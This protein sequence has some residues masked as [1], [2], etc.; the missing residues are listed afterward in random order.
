MHSSTIRGTEFE[1]HWRSEVV[2]H[3]EF[4]ASF[5]DTDRVGVVAPH[6]TEG[7]GAI[8]LIM[9]YVTAFYDRYRERGSDIFAYPDFFTFQH[10]IPCADYGMC[11]I[12][13]Y[14]KNVHVADGAQRAT[15]A[16]NDRGV[17]VLL[18]PDG[19]AGEVSIEE[20]ELESARR[21]VGRC[22]AYSECGI[23]HGA[24]LVLE[25]RSDLLSDYALAV[26]KSVDADGS[27]TEQRERWMEQVASG[28][29]RQSFRELE[30]GD[31][32]RKV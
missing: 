6:R 25:C 5:R 8:T 16:I 24:D 1:I 21:N 22:F 11:D 15:E 13:P 9:S 29:L 32:L 20:V 26:L 23:T 14:H 10:E 2:P 12:W 3:G 27:S 18:V 30:L 17:N 7:I 4:F 28:T 31:A 19:D